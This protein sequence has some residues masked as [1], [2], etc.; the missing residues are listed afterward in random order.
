MSG[1]TKGDPIRTSEDYLESLRRRDLDV[2]L[3]GERVEEPVDHPIIRPSINAVAATY[4]LAVRD[5]ELA[6]ARS[7]ITGERVNRFLHVTES[8]EDVVAQNRMQRR[9]GRLTGTCFQ[10]CVGMDA[11]NSLYSVTYDVDAAHGT[12]YHQRF[13]DFLARSQQQGYVLG[14][15]MTDVKGDRSK[16]PSEQADPDLYLRI[17]DRRDDGIVIRGAKAHQTGCINSHWILV[18]PTLRLTAADRDYAV[19]C[20]IPV[21]APGLTYIYGRQSCDTRAMEPGDIDVGNAAYSGQEAMIIIDDVF[22]PWNE[23]FLDGEYEFAA[24]L[25]ERFTAYHRRSY[26]CKSGVGDVLIGAAALI[27]EYNG[28]DRASHIRDKLVEMNHLN[29]TIYG[30]GIAA[31]HESHRTAAGNYENDGMLANVCKHHVTA[32]PYEIGRLAQ[33]L[34]GGL[35]TTLPSEAELQHAR[36]GPLLEKYLAGRADVPTEHRIRV[37]RLIE[38]MTMGRNAVGYL[39]ESMHGAGS[40]QAQRIQIARLADMDA[41]KAAAK[42]LAGIEGTPG[43]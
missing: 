20:A 31:S 13:R 28:V 17:V 4:D 14:G 36:L 18:M 32:Y 23:V 2:W 11:I 16:A 40:P 3:L 27:A 29:E 7:A 39:T 25:V 21:D 8:V 5:P 24:A 6:T 10:R 9:L 38:N 34:A 1:W 35:V 15:A 12:H 30:T 26:V 37:L 22:V 19:V 42:R 33:D 43:T 41:K